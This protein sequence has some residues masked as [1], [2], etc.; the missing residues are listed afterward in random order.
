MEEEEEAGDVDVD[1]VTET[2]T[3][4]TLQERGTERAKQNG[5]KKVGKTVTLFSLRHA[6]GHKGGG[7]RGRRGAVVN[8]GI[9]A[10]VDKWEGKRWPGRV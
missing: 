5:G 8:W 3:G 4:E 7:S 1:G 9:D 6:W 10:V 2:K